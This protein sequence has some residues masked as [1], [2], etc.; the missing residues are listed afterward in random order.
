[1]YEFV[2]LI[3][4]IVGVHYTALAVGHLGNAVDRWLDRR[5]D[6]RLTKLLRGTD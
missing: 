6:A 2:K 3:L 1:M 5:G 4:L